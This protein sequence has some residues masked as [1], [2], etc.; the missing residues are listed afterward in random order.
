M[1]G[2]CGTE[3]FGPRFNLRS[4]V[5]DKRQRRLLPGDQRDA[6]EPTL[7]D[8]WFELGY[9]QHLRSSAA[10]ASTRGRGGELD[11]D[12]SNRRRTSLLNIQM[13]AARKA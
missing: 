6:E 4:A 5:G 3:L 10:P 12:Y 2:N 8:P 13:R 1:I 11:T 7:D 9:A